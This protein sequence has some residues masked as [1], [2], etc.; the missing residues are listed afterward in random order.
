VI[1]AIKTGLSLFNKATMLRALSKSVKSNRDE[2]TEV[3]CD[4]KVP[5]EHTYQV[6]LTLLL[7][8][9]FAGAEEWHVYTEVNSAAKKCAIV[10]INENGP[11]YVIEIIAHASSKGA[12][13]SLEEHFNRTDAYRK[14]LKATEAWVINFT[15]HPSKGYIWP[16]NSLSVSAIHIYH[17][18]DWTQ[19]LVVTSPDDLA[20]TSINL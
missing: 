13:D 18:L 5:N 7:R 3:D 15:T 17:K 12:S 20:G 11:R 6:E 14:Q 19:A 1:A 16:K 8:K 10:V 4:A 9:W 2:E